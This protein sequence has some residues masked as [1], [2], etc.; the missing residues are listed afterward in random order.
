MCC[1]TLDNANTD[2]GLHVSSTIFWR[3]TL[4]FYPSIVNRVNRLVNFDIPNTTFGE[5]AYPYFLVRHEVFCSSQFLGKPFYLVIP[6]Y[7]FYLF[8][9]KINP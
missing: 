5:I 3:K 7:F 2:L 1:F 6:F 8:L 9:V 4:G